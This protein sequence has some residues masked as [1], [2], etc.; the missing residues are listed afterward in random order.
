VTEPTAPIELTGTASHLTGS[1]HQPDDALVA[2]LSTIC[3]TITSASA[4]A[5]ASRDWWPLALHWSIAG[6]VAQRAGAVCR[7]TS[8]D[9]VAAVLRTCSTHGVPV[10]AAGGRSGVS[11]A[12]IPVFGGVVL[13]LTAMQGI[14]DIDAGSGVV[15]VW[16]GTFG[17]EL[18]AELRQRCA[19]T[20][21]HFPQS[22]DLATVGGWVAC[23]GAGQY[24]TR[25]GKIEEMC[26]GLEVVLAD[27]TVIRTGHGP[28]SAMGPDL[29]HL[30]LGSEGTLG[31]ITRVWLRAHP[32]PTHERRA[33]YTFADFE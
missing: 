26:L 14:I 18:E 23:R 8:A 3:E 10:T 1:T 29:T 12:S 30:F 11:G 16:A 2:Q 32:V 5:E 7:P 24:S 20:I 9:E 15:E 31:I 13:D 28:A 17:P 25:Y 33:A 22:F 27:G 21:G 19:A 6:S 4:T